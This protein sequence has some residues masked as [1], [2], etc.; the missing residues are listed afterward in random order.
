M[1]AIDDQRQAAIKRLG[2]KR[3]FR[4]HLGLYVVVNTMLITIWAATGAGYFWPIWP[5]AGWGVGLASHA[6]TTYFKK[7]MTE[8]DIEAEMR[9]QRPHDSLSR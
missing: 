1:T 9:R 3:E 4:N 6:F 7:P 5:I 2:A 8:E